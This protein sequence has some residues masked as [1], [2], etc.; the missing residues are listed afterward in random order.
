MR[1]EFK[2]LICVLAAAMLFPVSTA[3]EPVRKDLSQLRTMI[4]KNEDICAIIDLGCL[5]GVSTPDGTE[6]G[7]E[8]GTEDGIE[9]GIENG[10]EDGIENGTEDGIENGTEDG[11]ENRI[12]N[13]IEGYSGIAE[14]AEAY[15]FMIRIPEERIISAGSNY[16]AFCFVPADENASVTVCRAE[17]P[18]EDGTL[19]K[20]D[21]LYEGKG[22]PFIVKCMVG[23]IISDVMVTVT[24]SQGDAITNYN[25]MY[26]G[27][28]GSLM[29]IEG[30]YNATVVSGNSCAY[31]DEDNSHTTGTFGPAKSTEEETAGE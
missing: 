4:N 10:T 3:A 22:E 2:T 31:G 6:D 7:I 16:N 8:N 30:L 19:S 12:E 21:V 20:G 27:R 11:I 14:Q 1:G 24:D 15:P 17:G 18:N 9:N 25:P 29:T 23:D 26:S 5:D 13:R 28:D